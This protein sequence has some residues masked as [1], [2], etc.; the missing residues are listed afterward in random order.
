M[1][2]TASSEPS[3]RSTIPTVI[4]A[5][6][7]SECATSALPQPRRHSPK[8]IQFA[9]DLFAREVNGSY[10]TFSGAVAL[11]AEILGEEGL[12]EYHRLAAEAW[13]KL[14]RHKAGSHDDDDL[15]DDLALRDILDF[16]AERAGDVDARIALRSRDLSSPWQYLQLAQFC[17]AQGRRD[18]ALRR[19][20]EGLWV[21]E[22]G[23]LDERL[24]SFTAG[25]LSDA[26]R[27]EEAEAHLWKASRRRRA[28][29]SIAELR[30]LAA[31]A[32]YSA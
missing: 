2:S 10:G 17:L 13:E 3:R 20:E 16:F 24:V 22:D 9:R 12:A 6:C 18:E 14:S 7:S 8:S 1:R 31:R 5:Y 19:A 25:L 26:G 27:R 28:S 30:H 4:A 11:Y 21:F 15:P 32:C 29:D 23:R